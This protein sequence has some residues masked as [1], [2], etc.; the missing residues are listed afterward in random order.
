MTDRPNLTHVHLVGSVGLDTVEEVLATAGDFLGAHLKR[1]PDGEPGGRR[2]WISWQYPLLRSCPFLAL[3]EEQAS[4]IRTGFSRLTLAEGVEAEHIRF[5][6]LG[7]A[8]EAR[9]SYLDFLDARKSGALPRGVRFQVS[10]PTPVAVIGA[11]TDPETARAVTPAYMEAMLREVGR[12]CDAIPHDDLTI[13]WD[14]CIE[15][16]MW[17]GRHGFIAEFPGMEQVFAGQFAALSGAVPAAVELGF[18][19]CYGDWDAKHFIEPED[20]AKMVELANFIC[21]N[22]HRPVSY[23]HM[24]VPIKRDDEAFFAPMDALALPEGTELIL[25]LVHAADG[26]AGTRRRI[27]A[28]GRHVDAFGIA[29]ECGLARARSPELVHEILRVHTEVMEAG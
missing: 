12:L 3:A 23:V 27:A 7:Y 5:P 28:A 24:P 22:A 25:G 4:P 1:L 11:Y 18:H 16:V 9:A 20:A 21:A 17:D 6:E 15:M 10:L 26:A 8:R 13:Q 2:L 29:S 14:V 19:L